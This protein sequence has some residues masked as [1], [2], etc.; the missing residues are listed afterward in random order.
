MHMTHHPARVWLH[1]LQLLKLLDF[2]LI[3]VILQ[4]PGAVLVR[5]RAP[6]HQVVHHL[7]QQHARE[8]QRCEKD[9]S[10]AMQH[11]F[12]FFYITPTKAARE[13]IRMALG[14]CKDT[15]TPLV[16]ENILKRSHKKKEKKKSKTR[17]GT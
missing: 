4:L 9:S 2:T 8:S 17:S 3:H 7:L 11:F 16:V 10:E 15:K 12:F 13:P 6:L 5:Q 1:C 14:T